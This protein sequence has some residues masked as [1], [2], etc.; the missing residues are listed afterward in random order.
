MPSTPMSAS[1]RGPSCPRGYAWRKRRPAGL[2]ACRAAPTVQAVFA[3]LRAHHGNIED[4]VPHGFACGRHRGTALADLRR[5]TVD[6]P[7]DLGF[8]HHRAVTARVTLLRP[9][10][11]WVGACVFRKS[12]TGRFGIVTA[13][14]GNVTDDF[15]DVTDGI[16]M[17]A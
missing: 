1:A 4:L 15:G 17:A 11:A 16:L 14:F 12:V 5:G 7:V 3:Y 8:V 13:E 10:L 2:A 6:D 9:A